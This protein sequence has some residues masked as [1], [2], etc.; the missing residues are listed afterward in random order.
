MAGA[1]P[2]SARM[3]CTAA[4]LKFCSVTTNGSCTV[5]VMRLNGS[6]SCFASQL[7]SLRPRDA[8][9]VRGTIGTPLFRAMW[10]TPF[11]STRGGP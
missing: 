1:G 11:F 3:T 4:Q 10:S 8:R 6:G 9:I 5:T 7:G 2:S